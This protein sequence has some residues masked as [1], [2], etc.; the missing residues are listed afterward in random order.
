MTVQVRRQTIAPL[1]ED[2]VLRVAACFGAP[3]AV[4]LGH[5]P[6]LP[7]RTRRSVDSLYVIASNGS[8]IQYD[9]EPKHLSGTVTLYMCLA[10]IG[11]PILITDLAKGVAYCFKNRPFGGCQSSGS[12]L[13]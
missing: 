9:L 7:S 12:L 3:R 8:L 11:N 1:T 13:D 2:S 4:P 10:I 6:H 5:S